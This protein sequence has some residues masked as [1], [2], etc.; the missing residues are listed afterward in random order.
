MILKEHPIPCSAAI[1]S[2]PA[3][4]ERARRIGRLPRLRKDSRTK[5]N[6]TDVFVFARPLNE[7]RE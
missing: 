7:A 2:C 6:S 1:N 4:D 5:M 3:D